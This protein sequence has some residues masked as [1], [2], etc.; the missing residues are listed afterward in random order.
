MSKVIHGLL[1]DCFDRVLD[2]VLDAITPAKVRHHLGVRG[3]RLESAAH[4]G[5]RREV[6]A[7]RG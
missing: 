7:V 2:D 4:E 5:R 1:N 3:W 6:V